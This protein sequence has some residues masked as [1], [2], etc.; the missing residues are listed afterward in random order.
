MNLKLYRQ[1]IKQRDGFTV[2]QGEDS[3]PYADKDMVIVADGLGGRGGFPHTKMDRA[4]LDEEKLYDILFEPE[5]EA[6]VSDEFRAF[7][8]NN[9][10]E[11][12]K[13]K[14]YYDN[15]L[16][17]DETVRRSGYF[18]S[19]IVVAIALY[20]LKYNPKF[21]KERVFAEFDTLTD[22]QKETR[23][24]YFADK[25]AEIVLEKLARIAERAGFEMEVGNKGAYLLP[26][27][28][29]V[30]LLNERD[31]GVDVLYLWAGD[32]RGYFWTETEGMAQV[33]E[34]HEEGETMT[35]LITLSRECKIEGRFLTL[36]KPCAIFC[37]TDGV[38]K[39]EA[40]ACP[41]DQEFLMLMVIDMYDNPDDAMKLLVDQYNSLSVDDSSTMALYGCGYE[42]YADFRAAVKR[43]MALINEKYV[44]QLP[45]LFD[46]DYQGDLNRLH[47]KAVRKFADEG[48]ARRLLASPQILNI[49]VNDME[50]RRYAPY[51]EVKNGEAEP[52]LVTTAPK[53]A[54]WARLVEY[55]KN[56][57]LVGEGIRKY[58]P[59][60]RNKHIDR[61]GKKGGYKMASEMP[62]PLT[63]LYKSTIQ[64][65]MARLNEAY[66]SDDYLDLLADLDGEEKVEAVKEHIIALKKQVLSIVEKEV[67]AYLQFRDEQQRLTREYLEFDKETVAS[68][69]ER[70][71]RLERVENMSWAASPSCPIP[72]GLKQ[73]HEAYI[74]ACENV[75]DTPA[76]EDNGALVEVAV[77]Y[78][79]G[80]RNIHAFIWNQYRELV[81]DSL[82]EDILDENP[83][84]AAE[85]KRLTEA[86]ATR[87]R[88]YGEYN[89]EY[90][91][92]YRPS[93]L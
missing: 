24:K 69:L 3:H 34:D 58:I 74:A 15:D 65:Q 53:D 38:Y 39:P 84:D 91:R 1:K 72:M 76:G 45:G 68:L 49:V 41:I 14:S 27:T 80:N 10:E 16:V 62:T 87:S 13:T 4:I 51:L 17:N 9:F 56:N 25:L 81:S 66:R 29:T 92:K 40:F 55:V 93:R 32:S 52:A 90:N 19:R 86:L 70:L 83:T 26:S 67:S 18:A 57:W 5:F 42:T 30:A 22:E 78:W 60:I 28:L 44:G 8:T 31:D 54:A 20:T 2:Y 89:K 11:L 23:A 64:S 21:S 43:R 59:E 88:V 79:C 61:C 36:P 75:S 33:T 7:V 77:K 71:E 37:A 48:V 85:L 6:E 12:F 35:N 50:K 63:S 46:V 47:A 82:I 73:V